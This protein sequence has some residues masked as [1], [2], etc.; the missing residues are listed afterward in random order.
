L[1][2]FNGADAR[3]IVACVHACEGIP[4]EALESGV[5]RELIEA[6]TRLDEIKRLQQKVQRANALAVAVEQALKAWNMGDYLTPFMDDLRDA[7]LDF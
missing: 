6:A 2:A 7:L 3:R 1:Y 5:V 4:T